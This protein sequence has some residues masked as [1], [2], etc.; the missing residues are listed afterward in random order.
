MPFSTPSV[1]L[2]KSDD[3]QGLQGITLV[4]HL[5]LAREAAE[6]IV[7]QTGAS[8]L[9]A[10]G[11]DPSIW[12]PR[13]ELLLP[14]AAALHDI[15]KANSHFQRLLAGV[16]E[17][18]G[19]RHEWV[20]FQLLFDAQLQGW[21]APVFVELD[22]L[23]AVA[24]A[25]CGH[26]PSA[27]ARP[28][29][30]APT[31]VGS[32]VLMDV[33]VDHP[34]FRTVLADLAQR[35]HLAT[36]PIFAARQTWRLT[37]A[38]IMARMMGVWT[39]LLIAWDT[40]SDDWKKFT[41]VLKASLIGADVAA[42]CV[43]AIGAAHEDFDWMREALAVRPTAEE[44]ASVVA[45][46]LA[47]GVPRRFQTDVANAAGRVV[48]VTAG[49][50]SGKTL[51]AW[52]RAATHPQ[53]QHRRLYFCYP[54]TG[55]ATE[56]YRDYLFDDE[57]GMSKINASLFH[58]R[59]R[60]DQ[61]LILHQH[62]PDEDEEIIA[63]ISSLKAWGVPV[64]ACTVD[65]VLGLMQNQRKGLYA[66]PVLAQSAFIFDEIHSFDDKLFGAL[67]RFLRDLPGL[68]V[69]LMTASLPTNRLAAI[70]GILAQNNETLTVVRGPEELETLP[71]YRRSLETPSSAM[72]I[73]QT[74]FP[75]PKIL[76][77]SNTVAR[78]MDAADAMTEAGPI[79]YH[80]RFKYADRLKCHGAVI[81][82]FRAASAALAVTTQVCEMS[83]NLSA[84]LLITELAPVPAM[85]QRLGRLNRTA[86]PEHH[87]LRP[88]VVVVPEA[89]LPYSKAEMEESL[90]WL[91]R[92]GY[93][94]LSQQSLV[95]AWLSSTAPVEI[96]G[97][98]WLDG[99]PETHVV[100]LR[101][102]SPGITVL[103]EED[104]GTVMSQP[105]RLLEFL[106]PMPP[107]PRGLELLPWNRL[108]IA[109]AGSIHYDSQ[110]GGQWARLND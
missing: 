65:T 110:R 11:L 106:L 28:F 3:G 23:P 80:S 58:S 84:D 48:L 31:G 40:I 10:A 14:L 29:P 102:S 47:G 24:C 74:A 104:L 21:L 90:A 57:I 51:A 95:D 13:L 108:P 38:G 73:V 25:I 6:I 99:G 86:S 60:V 4:E 76:C 34:D 107:A 87:S 85:I 78:C 22:S 50:G 63:R 41:A 45:D 82:S 71:R 15:G 46:R 42:S 93:E 97:S 70:N 98:A 56:G 109:P 64:A 55:T 105:F 12:Q 2:A 37:T 62:E 5:Q 52:M 1:L 92:L 43:P 33:Y 89:E 20:S 19:M 35:F 16:P 91:E 9:T 53:W 32:D 39:N 83:L 81:D 103:M 49:C 67:L 79:L 18:Q 27:K 94:P 36:P 44:L 17:L 75:R 26:H 7:A 30:P 96:G 100:S 66:W 69:L 72:A 88:F 101:G 8:Q 61:R 54:T 59:S 68:P 77:V